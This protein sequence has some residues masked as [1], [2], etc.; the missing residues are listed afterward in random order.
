MAHKVYLDDITGD[1][2]T[3]YIEG[4]DDHRHGILNF[5]HEYSLTLTG[6]LQFLYASSTDCGECVKY[7]SREEFERNYPKVF[8]AIEKARDENRLY[9]RRWRWNAKTSHNDEY[10]IPYTAL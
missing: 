7:A 5:A 6:A 10:V 4:E 1:G 9:V 8:P 3:L 2:K